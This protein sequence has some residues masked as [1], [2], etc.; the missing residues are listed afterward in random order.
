M[1]C[2]AMFA[3]YRSVRQVM[4][5]QNKQWPPAVTV[6]D[7]IFQLKWMRPDRTWRKVIC[8]VQNVRANRQIVV[9]GVPKRQEMPLWPTCA[10]TA[11]IRPVQASV[12][13]RLISPMK[14]WWREQTPLLNKALRVN[15]SVR[16]AA[17]R[18]MRLYLVRQRT[19]ISLCQE[20]VNTWDVRKDG[21]RA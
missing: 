5:R 1:I 3:F 18:C 4:T 9:N 10:A 16:L 13:V 7:G 19:V 6:T 17:R 2:K 15:R 21:H 14:I 8:F 11:R 12:Q 20:N